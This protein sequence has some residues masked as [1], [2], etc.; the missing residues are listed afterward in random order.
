[1]ENKNMKFNI[2]FFD[3]LFFI[4]NILSTDLY[5]VLKVR[6]TLLAGSSLNL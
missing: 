1:M 3:I 4:S 2:Q 5:C 6:K